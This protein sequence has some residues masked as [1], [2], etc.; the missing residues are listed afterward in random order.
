MDRKVEIIDVRK[1]V[2]NIESHST[3]NENGKII[4]T[5]HSNNKLDNRD[6]SNTD[7]KCLWDNI[8]DKL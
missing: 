4:Y 8:E 1:T 2:N 7:F 6:D 5:D 3:N